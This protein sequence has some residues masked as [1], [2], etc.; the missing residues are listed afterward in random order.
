MD[1]AKQV[2]PS[3]WCSAEG[4]KVT[5]VTYWLSVKAGIYWGRPYIKITIMRNSNN[6]FKLDILLTISRIIVIWLRWPKGL[7]IGACCVHINNQSLLV[8]RNGWWADVIINFIILTSSSYKQNREQQ[9]FN[10]IVR[11]N[12]FTFTLA[13]LYIFLSQRKSQRLTSS[14]GSE[15][16][17]Q[18][19]NKIRE[20][21]VPFPGE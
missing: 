19:V 16:P 3:Q 15:N 17:S 4:H 6:E 11:N 20:L 12:I 2:L 14:F 9:I 18:R 5:I 21:T 8:E 10:L 7:L 1:L 13:E